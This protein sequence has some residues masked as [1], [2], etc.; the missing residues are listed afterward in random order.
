MIEDSPKLGHHVVFPRVNVGS[1][2]L[3]PPK[4]LKI[5][6][7]LHRELSLVFLKDQTMIFR[8]MTANRIEARRRRKHV[9]VL[10]VENALS[11]FVT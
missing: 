3:L 10:A 6:F 1:S 4:S 11:M 5:F 8:Q 2:R 9:A 7:D